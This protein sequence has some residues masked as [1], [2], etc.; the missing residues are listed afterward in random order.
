MDAR[1]DERNFGPGAEEAQ[2][3][4][5]MSKLIIITDTEMPGAFNQEISMAVLNFD[6]DFVYRI[7]VVTDDLHK[8]HMDFS[9]L[10]L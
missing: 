10:R 4:Q 8:K 6:T 9:E 1:P 5:H 2:K 7:N 3:G